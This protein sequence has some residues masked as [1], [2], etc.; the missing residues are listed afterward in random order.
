LARES[1]GALEQDLAAEKIDDQV[2]TQIRAKEKSG[3]KKKKWGLTRHP[4]SA[5][6][7]LRPGIP[8]PRGAGHENKDR[9]ENRVQQANRL[10]TNSREGKK[11]TDLD[12]EPTESEQD[13]GHPE[14]NERSRSSA[15]QKKNEQHTRDVK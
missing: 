15:N 14:E 4:G 11:E 12:L 2:R 8:V 7:G 10:A 3:Q 5:N 1:A 6:R 9:E 13:L